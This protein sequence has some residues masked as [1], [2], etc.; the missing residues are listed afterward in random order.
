M[1][2]CTIVRVGR[3]KGGDNMYYLATCDSEGKCFGFLK[4][5]KTISKNPDK[6]MDDLLGFRTK[7]I[8]Q[9]KALQIN[10]GHL[11]LPNGSPYRVAV[12]KE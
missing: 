9:E 7:A 1:S 3:N 11:L 5:D 6:E 10:M 4:N 2:M 8:A 12:V